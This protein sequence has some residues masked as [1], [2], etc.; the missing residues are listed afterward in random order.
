[1][2]IFNFFIV[3]PQIVNALIGGPLVKYLYNDNA[4][5]ALVSSGV[6]FLIAAALVT[7]VKDTE[8]KRL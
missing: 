4:I 5:F 6:S 7:R 2:G 3:I 1:M 8:T